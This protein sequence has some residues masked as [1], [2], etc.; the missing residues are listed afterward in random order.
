VLKLE[1]GRIIKKYPGLRNN[2]ASLKEM[3]KMIKLLGLMIVRILFG[4]KTKMGR[5]M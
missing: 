3:M 4:I 5:I 2:I 1:Y